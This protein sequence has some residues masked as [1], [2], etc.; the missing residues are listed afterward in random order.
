YK[1]A[2]VVVDLGSRLTDAA[3][4]KNKKS[5]NLVK[6]FQKIYKRGILKIPRRLEVDAGLEFQGDL[7]NW[8]IENGVKIRV[9]KPHR[10]RQQAIVERQN[11]FIGKELF[12]RMTAQEL[13]TGETSTQW[14]TDLPG[15]VTKLN[16]R[17][18]LKRKRKLKNEYDCEGD[19]CNLL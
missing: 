3:P 11:Q 5:S 17:K 19:A 12:K 13:L 14:V 1:Y 7:S 10:H 4:L 18:S 9:A 15:I 6:A 16:E 8:F 2:L